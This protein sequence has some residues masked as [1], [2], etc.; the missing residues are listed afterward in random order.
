MK[1]L[2]V[3]VCLLAVSPMVNAGK[4]TLQLT[5]QD[6]TENGKTLCRYENS[7]YDKSITIT[8]KHCPST[9]TFDTE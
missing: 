4:I 5:S 2:H 3:W 6:K 7:I 9:R 8:G 1:K